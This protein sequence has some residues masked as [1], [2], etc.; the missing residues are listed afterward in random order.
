MAI[1]TKEALGVDSIEKVTA[2]ALASHLPQAY[3]PTPEDWEYAGVGV[4]SGSQ[5]RH[6]HAL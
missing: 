4:N 1:R 2:E 3:P 5:Q 6:R